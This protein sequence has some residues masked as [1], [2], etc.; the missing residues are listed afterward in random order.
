MRGSGA[1]SPVMTL[2]PSEQNV[3]M[4]YNPKHLVKS[5]LDSE[6]ELTECEGAVIC[7]QQLSS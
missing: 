7:F 1:P 2:R 5:Q 4:K 3:D 6:N